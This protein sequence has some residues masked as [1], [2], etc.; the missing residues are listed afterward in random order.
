MRVQEKNKQPIYYALYQGL[1]E[2][3]DS[4]GLSTGE[5]ENSY[6]TPVQ[7]KLNVSANKGEAKD[8]MFGTDLNYSKKIVSAVDL[9]WD[10]NTIL[11]IGKTAGSGS[12]IT[13]HNFVVVAVAKSINSVTYAIKGVDVSNGNQH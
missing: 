5:Y 6:T 13:P 8:E 11:W 10:E 3:I 4:D 9:G 12:T 7:I 1:T 2:I